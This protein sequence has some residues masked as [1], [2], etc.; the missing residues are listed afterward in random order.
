MTTEPTPT[1]IQPA[2]DHHPGA[3]VGLAPGTRYRCAGC[4]N[5]TRFDV[6]VEERVTRYWHV[7]VSGAGAVEQQQVHDRRVT[8]V[9]CRWC[10]PAGRIDVEPVPPG[11]ERAG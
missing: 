2:G 4:G 5:L 7:A 11:G 9:T 10:G 1:A 8:A 6:A 3:E